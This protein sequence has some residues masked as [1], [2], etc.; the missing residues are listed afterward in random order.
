MRAIRCMYM[1]G[2]RREGISGD[3]YNAPSN[4]IFILLAICLLISYYFVECMSLAFL[5]HSV[6]SPCF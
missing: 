6:V 5:S 1:G 4:I 2:Q 3:T